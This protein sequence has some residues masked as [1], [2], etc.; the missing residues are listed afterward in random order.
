MLRLVRR[1]AHSPVRVG[2]RCCLDPR[3]TSPQT[4][5]RTRT[6]PAAA[7]RSEAGSRPS[8]CSP[9]DVARSILPRWVRLR[10]R[11]LTSS[12][13]SRRCAR[14]ERSSFTAAAAGTARAGSQ[15]SSNS[16]LPERSS[17]CSWHRGDHASVRSGAAAEQPASRLSLSPTDVASAERSIPEPSPG[18]QVIR[19]DEDRGA[20]RGSATTRHA[21]NASSSAALECRLLREVRHAGRM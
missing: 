8:P 3:S 5:S 15:R 19:R 18:A 17:A 21:E 11:H 4:A 10:L 12:T 2:A 6:S 20:C 13:C 7:S 14:A 1:L 9:R 16:S